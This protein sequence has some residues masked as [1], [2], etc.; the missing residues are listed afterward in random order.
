MWMC[1]CADSAACHRATWLLSNVFTDFT[2]LRAQQLQDLLGRGVGWG[3]EGS[4]GGMGGMGEYGWV[5]YL[6]FDAASLS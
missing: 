4:V 1:V 3:A 5:S 6:S 2:D